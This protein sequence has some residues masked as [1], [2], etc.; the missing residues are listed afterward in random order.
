MWVVSLL[1]NVFCSYKI[2]VV[3]LQL[4]VGFV[5]V[6]IC[7]VA[8]FPIWFGII[9]GRK[10]LLQNILCI[11]HWFSYAIVPPPMGIMEKSVADDSGI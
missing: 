8:L 11:T 3:S 9:Q 7:S 10:A 6:S 1:S 5:L 2:L 4:R